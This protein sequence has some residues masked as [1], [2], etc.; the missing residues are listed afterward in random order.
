MHSHPSQPALTPEQKAAMP[1]IKFDCSGFKRNPDG[2]WVS[3]KISD[4]QTPEFTV[5]VNP[6]ILFKK[7]RINWSLNVV[8]AL[9]ENCAQS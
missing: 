3:T 2:S 4:I 6:G 9:E 1:K 8:E 7:D 5:R